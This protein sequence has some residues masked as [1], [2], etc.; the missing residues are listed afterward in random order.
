MKNVPYR[1]R[2]AVGIPR[3]P[4]NQ[5]VVGST[6]PQLVLFILGKGVSLCFPM[7][8][9]HYLKW[10]PG[11]RQMADLVRLLNVL[12]LLALMTFVCYQGS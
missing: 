9:Q 10:V 4:T 7:S 6:L 3:L 1:R 11:H 5:K 8:T 2:L 12:V